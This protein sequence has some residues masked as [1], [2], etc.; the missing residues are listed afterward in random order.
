MVYTILT[1]LLPWPDLHCVG[2]L[3]FAEEFGYIFLP[4]IGE[5]QKKSH[6]LS[7]GPQPGIVSYCGESGPSNRIT[8]I[9][10]LDESLR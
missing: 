2:P 7:A 6:Y 1:I 5:D 3:A 9:K 10:W 4:N 8:F